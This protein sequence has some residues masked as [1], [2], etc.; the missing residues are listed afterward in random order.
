MK[1]INLDKIRRINLTIGNKKMLFNFLNSSFKSFMSRWLF[2]VSHKDIGILYLSF[3]LFAGLVGTS[4]SMFIRL[5]LGLPGR[6]LLDGAGQLYNGA[7]CHT[8]LSI[9]DLITAVSPLA[10]KAPGACVVGNDWVRSLLERETLVWDLLNLGCLSSYEYLDMDTLRNLLHFNGAQVTCFSMISNGEYH[11]AL[12]DAL[13]GECWTSVWQAQSIWEQ[14]VQGPKSW[15]LNSVGSEWN[16]GWP[17]YRKGEGYGVSILVAAFFSTSSKG[18]RAAKG[19]STAGLNPEISDLVKSHPNSPIVKLAHLYASPEALIYAYELIKSNPGNMTKGLDDVTLD[20]I[21]R[22]YLDRISGEILSGKYQFKPIRRVHIP[23]PGSS[24]MRPL[25]IASPRDKIV[26]KALQLA[27]NSVYEPIFSE[28]SHGFRPHKGCHT[29]LNFVRMKFSGCRWILES[30][31]KK[32]FDRIDHKRFLEIV[33]R[34]VNCPITLGLLSSALKA[35]YADDLGNVALVNELGSPQGSILSPLICNIYMHEM[36]QFMESFIEEFNSS[37][38]VRKRNP[39]YRS[40]ER[41]LARLTPG[42]SE[43]RSVRTQMRSLPSYDLMDSS[44]RRMYYV[45][46]ADDFLIGVSGS[47]SD[48]CAIRDKLQVWLITNLMLELH[49]N[50]TFIRKLSAE[51]VKFLGVLIGPLEDP[52]TRPV[53]LYSTGRRSRVTSRLAMR[54]DLVALYKRLKDR[55]FVYYNKNLRI[56]KGQHLGGM[57]NLDVLD[58]ITF[59]NSVFRGIWNYFGFVDNCSSLQKVW[60]SMQESLAFTLS[61][62]FRLVGIKDIFRRFGY[63]TKFEGREFWRPDTW[64]RDS[65]RLIDNLRSS[66]TYMM[67]YQDFVSAVRRSWANK[68]TRSNI[69]LSCIICDESKDVQMHHVKQIKDLKLNLD[70]FTMQMAAINRKQ[71]PL[72]KTHHINLHRNT[73]TEWERLRFAE[74]CRRHVG[75]SYP[76]R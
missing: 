3:A 44:F 14:G 65:R 8:L 7:P 40:L 59:Y 58:I 16:M 25:G 55:G 56:Y 51:S 42:S 57:Q 19:G 1:N 43:W 63:P 66:G 33:S 46:Y 60:W 52:A 27:L 4:L 18:T 2:S 35:G 36:D 69:G 48:V 20:G 39:A 54:V 12:I 32:C 73:L 45:R 70:F 15:L 24:E 5:E 6:G 61:R 31:I 38:T 34:R 9:G 76:K 30:D 68:L 17:Y 49:P 47:Y 72:C 10:D 11:T 22:D 21:D 13:C 23:K 67:S 29:A 41:S 71:V 75:K 62:K 37:T 64:V 74:G 28:C 26:Q 53:R 50:K